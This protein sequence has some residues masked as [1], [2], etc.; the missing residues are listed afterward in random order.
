MKVIYL[1]QA[2]AYEGT[3]FRP[4]AIVFPPDPPFKVGE[5]EEPATTTQ[6]KEEAKHGLT[7]PS[8]ACP[9]RARAI[10]NSPR[11]RAKKPDPREQEPPQQGKNGSPNKPAIVPPL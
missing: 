2:L 11:A 5:A 10:R 3:D 8:G 4:P 7:R 6:R 9:L 1:L